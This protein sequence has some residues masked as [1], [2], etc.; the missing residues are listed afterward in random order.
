M[1]VGGWCLV[2]GRPWLGVDEGEGCR[3]RVGGY[4]FCLRLQ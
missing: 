4:A 2:F 3:Y 1:G